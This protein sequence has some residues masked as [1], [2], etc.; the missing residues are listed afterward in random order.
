[1]H[2]QAMSSL[3]RRLA[4]RLGMDVIARARSPVLLLLA[5]SIFII[6]LIVPDLIP[7]VDEI[8]LGIVTLVLAR[9]RLPGATDDRH[10]DENQPV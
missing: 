9:R 3:L 6:D 2:N 1:M 5:A 10:R 7:F 4:A 8:L